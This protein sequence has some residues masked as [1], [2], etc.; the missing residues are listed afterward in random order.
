MPSNNSNEWHVQERDR[1]RKRERK[2]KYIRSFW[3][4]VNIESYIRARQR[5]SE[6]EIKSKNDNR[7]AN[8]QIKINTFCLSR[9]STIWFSYWCKRHTHQTYNKRKNKYVCKYLTYQIVLVYTGEDA[10]VVITRGRIVAEQN[11]GDFLLVYENIVSGLSQGSHG[12]DC[13][14]GRSKQI[15]HTSHQWHRTF[16]ESHSIAGMAECNREDHTPK[17]MS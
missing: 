3:H 10:A 4:P 9:M 15:M 14:P 5:A 11:L 17:F 7:E 2:G 13:K 1:G 6:W 16:Q 8:K 12:S